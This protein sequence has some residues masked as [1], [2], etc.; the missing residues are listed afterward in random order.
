MTPSLVAC[1][2]HYRMIAT[3]LE[4]AWDDGNATGLDGWTGP[5]RGSEPD[6]YAIRLRER[7]V[8]RLSA[9]IASAIRAAIAHVTGGAA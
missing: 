2:H 6:D 1:C 5:G 3:R 7:T 4:S 9:E 8:D